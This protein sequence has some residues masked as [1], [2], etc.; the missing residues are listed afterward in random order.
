[1]PEPAFKNVSQRFAGSLLQKVY[2]CGMELGKDCKPE[3]VLSLKALLVT[4]LLAEETVKRYA[5]NSSVETEVLA[6]KVP[7]AALLTPTYIANALKKVSSRDFDVVLVPGL[8]R[9]DVAVIAD[10]TGVP[11]F[12]GSRYAADLPT[13]LDALGQVELSTVAPAC[14][15]LSEELRRRALQELA[16][17]EKNRDVLLKKRWNMLIGDL[18]VGKDFPMRVMAEIV[19][20]PLLST[21]EIQR[22]AKHYVEAGADIIDVG[23][24]VG[25]SRPAEAK[26]AVDAVKHVVNV[27]VSIDTFDPREIEEA[28]SAGADLVLSV[29]AGN[30]EEVAA[31]AFDVA[32]VVVP[33][34]QR[35]GYFPSIIEERAVFL[36]ENIKKARELG[37]AKVIG[38]LILEPTDVSG[39]MA[40]FREFAGRNPAVPLLVGVGNVTELM[41]A[42]SVG[43]N[44]LLARLS[45]EVGASILLTTEESDKTRGSVSEVAVASKMMFLAKKRA[46]VPQ[47]LHLDL[48]LLKDK[49]NREE[50]YSKTLEVEAQVITSTEEYKPTL[51]D[52]RGLFK[53]AADRLN[54][55]VVAMHF[56]AAQ[57]EKPTVII[58]GK[59]AENIYAKIVEMG[60]VTRLEHA[61]Y[62]GSELAKAEIALRTGKE[63]IQDKQLF[64]KH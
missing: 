44:A 30:V 47:D 38:D 45:A 15:M 62:L 48:L 18:P 51:F 61:A 1:M 28:V 29:D 6:L 3:L 21:D 27:P 13:V 22:L 25:E 26:R 37:I 33:T 36:E 17:V 2:V 11:T 43:V 8:I 60:L 9:G 63:Y 19:D 10:A 54:D 58:K 24:V 34:N 55:V 53:I 49:S 16:A 56:S 57:T 42:D 41:D 64:K 5:Q 20:A 23:M 4:G 59:T 14:D 32:V 39:S 12:K 46:S 7:V 35:R 50:P 52:A 31:F 40:A